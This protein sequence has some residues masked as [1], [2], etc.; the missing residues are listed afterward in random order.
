MRADEMFKALS[1]MPNYSKSSTKKTAVGAV[2]PHW[3]YAIRLSTTTSISSTAT[4]LMHQVSI[5]SLYFDK[6]TSKLYTGFFDGVICTYD[7]TAS[8]AVGG[9]NNK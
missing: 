4:A 9:V 5:T 7:F 3:I 8:A 1:C 2:D 6:T